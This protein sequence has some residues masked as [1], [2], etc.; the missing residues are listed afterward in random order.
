[1]CAGQ[2]HDDV[3]RGVACRSFRT[4]L[5]RESANFDVCGTEVSVLRGAIRQHGPRH[6]VEN[7]AYV[8]VVD[9][10]H[11]NAVE[12]EPMDELHERLRQLGKI[13]AIGSQ[14]VAVDI[15]HDR[16]HRLQMQE[17]C[18]AF[19]RLGNQVTARAQLRVTSGAVQQPADHEGRIEFRRLENRRDQT[20][21]RRLAVRSRDCDA[22]P[23][24]HQFA[25]HFCAGDDWN[26][27]GVRRDHFGIVAADRARHDDDIGTGDVVRAMP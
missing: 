13:A 6:R 22:V 16:H 18:V 1:M 12:R 11:R 17:R 10:Q 15:G 4:E 23:V 5:P 14:V 20:G 7:G 24:T 21:G 19:V 9:A 8:R 2:V 3:E 26:S 27:R 25:Q